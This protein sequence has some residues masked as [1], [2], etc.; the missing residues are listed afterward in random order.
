M[1]KPTKKSES[2]IEQ[3][4]KDIQKTGFVS[5][6]TLKKKKD[7][8]KVKSLKD[9][10]IKNINK[11]NPKKIEAFQYLLLR[12]RNNGYDFGYKD[13]IET[14]DI[15]TV[16]GSLNKEPKGID[17][18]NQNL[19][20][21]AREM[22]KELEKEMKGIKVEV[23][24]HQSMLNKRLKQEKL[25][26]EKRRREE[27]EF[28]NLRAIYN[29]LLPSRRLG[30]SIGRT[31]WRYLPMFIITLAIFNLFIF[32]FISGE[33]EASVSTLNATTTGLFEEI[34][35]EDILV[36][37]IIIGAVILLS[38]LLIRLFSDDY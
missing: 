36:I 35:I 30:R 23:T 26:A 4:Y 28:R 11:L 38:M 14:M 5:V 20:Y 22:A 34:L 9:I 15:K 13:W 12:L 18:E 24:Y 6:K 33:N 3:I 17:E 2:E 25:D 1:R 29:E 21:T 37:A 10:E 8:L 27:E 7:I 31:F 32:P 16:I 19:L